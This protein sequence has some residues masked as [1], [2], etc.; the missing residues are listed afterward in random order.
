VF[1]AADTA[2][3]GAAMYAGVI[4]DVDIHRTGLSPA[5]SPTDTSPVSGENLLARSHQAAVRRAD[6]AFVQD[7]EQYFTARRARAMR[8]A[9][10]LPWQKAHRQSR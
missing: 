3:L 1:A 7:V 8:S 4:S 10:I 6:T 2:T 5:S 9:E